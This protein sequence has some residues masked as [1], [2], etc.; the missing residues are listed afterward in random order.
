[1]GD[2]CL[3]WIDPGFPW[4]KVHDDFFEILLPLLSDAQLRV[5]LAVMYASYR[6]ETRTPALSEPQLAER[7]GLHKGTVWTAI[8]QLLELRLLKKLG[9]AGGRSKSNRYAL[10]V[11]GLAALRES[12][13]LPGCF[14]EKPPGKPGGAPPESRVDVPPESRVIIP[15]KAGWAPEKQEEQEEQQQEEGRAACAAHR[16]AAPPRLA[17]SWAQTAHRAA[18]TAEEPR[19]SAAEWSAEHQA[20]LV[21]AV[22]LQADEKQARQAIL[23]TGPAAAAAA[24]DRVD[25]MKNLRNPGGTAITAIRCGWT[26]HA[27]RKAAPQPPASSIQDAGDDT[28]ELLAQDLIRAW[29]KRKR[30]QAAD[31]AALLAGNHPD[32]PQMD[33]A[34]KRAQQRAEL[35]K[36]AKRELQNA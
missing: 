6:F 14:R 26:P 32:F 18:S 27:A 34:A 33:D 36:I 5:F 12:P 28:V 4:K 13:R 10:S 19:E 21:R 7:S 29:P 8:K 15:R 22:T 9:A 23:G 35:L 20:V 1:M 11:E 25:E 24:L 17:D 3:E 31:T 16:R 2:V 30:D